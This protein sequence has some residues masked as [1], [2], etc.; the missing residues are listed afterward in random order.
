MIYPMANSGERFCYS[1]HIIRQLYRNNINTASSHQMF[2]IVQYCRGILSASVAADS[3]NKDLYIKW[4]CF[5]N[6]GAVK[7]CLPHSL[8]FIKGQILWIWLA[9][10]DV[11]GQS[12]WLMPDCCLVA[13]NLHLMFWIT[14]WQMATKAFRMLVPKKR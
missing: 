11:N 7:I 13:S 2:R 8:C 9:S 5:I 14:F 4:I 6:C 3:F 10:S 1:N 12:N